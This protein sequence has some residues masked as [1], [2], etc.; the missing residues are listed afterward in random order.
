MAE[1]NPCVKEI[2][3]SFSDFILS[4]IKVL[5]AGQIAVLEAQIIT[6]RNQILQYNIILSS[7]QV[8]YTLAQKVADGV[9]ETASLI[10]LNQIATCADLGDFNINLQES[11]LNTLSVSSN[12]DKEVSMVSG[13]INT[14]N[15]FVSDA[16]A[17]IEQFTAIDSIINQCLG[18]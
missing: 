12:L 18:E 5:I 13:Y 1:L 9:M 11:I 14:L 3:C 8:Q 17:T 4:S 10:P 16:E 2:L 15:Q 6:Y 7:I